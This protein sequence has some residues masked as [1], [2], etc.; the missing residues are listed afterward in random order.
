VEGEFMQVRWA[1][2]FFVCVQLAWAQIDPQKVSIDL[3]WVAAVQQDR[4]WLITD[5]PAA[6]AMYKSK[7]TLQ[8]GDVLL[9]IDGHDISELGPLAVARLLEDVPFRTVPMI[10]ERSGN[11]VE[12][13]VFG[14]GVVTDGTIKSTR[15]YSPDE[16]QKRDDAAPRFSMIDLQGWQHT[17]ALYR[18]KWVLLNV[19]GTWCSGCLDEI[20]ALNYLSTNYSAR[21]IVIGVD[22]N[23]EA[24]TLQRFLAQHP[25]SYPVLL[26]GTFDDSFARSYN[27]HLAPTNVVI[28][29]EGKIT[30]VGRG[31]MSLKGA[32]ETIARGQRTASLRP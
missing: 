15:S 28:A 24:E 31:T 27:V 30:F 5:A 26:A 3:G 11:T 7:R 23:D 17:A 12:V 14:E 22:I 13:Q 2:C 6:P 21:V 20:P 1:L 19:W 25:L 9:S 16:L 29:P 32:V 10:L 18:G 8:V 4:G